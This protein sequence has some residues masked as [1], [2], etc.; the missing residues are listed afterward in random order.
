M[1]TYSK[2]SRAL[3]QHSTPE[4][5]EIDNVCNHISI[6]FYIPHWLALKSKQIGEGKLLY[7]ELEA[8][9]HY[10]GEKTNRLLFIM[11]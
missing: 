3:L 10:Y 11:K 9:L 2:A 1:C 6:I 8:V 4:Y 5:S 7:A